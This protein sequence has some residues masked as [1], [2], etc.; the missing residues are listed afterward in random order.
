MKDAK[1]TQRLTLTPERFWQ[2]LRKG[3]AYRKEMRESLEPLLKVRT[4]TLRT[5][6]Q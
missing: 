3:G 5:L 4:E 1:T 2:L 6:L